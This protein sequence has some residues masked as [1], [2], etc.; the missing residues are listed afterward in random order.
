MKKIFLILL[1][2]YTSLSIA[3]SYEKHILQN[4]YDKSPNT[5]LFC[6]IWGFLKFYHP[7]VANG[8][9]NWELEF[10]NKIDSF[11]KIQEK[12]EIS[13]FLQN[14]IGKL[15]TFKSKLKKENARNKYFDKNFNLSW[16]SDTIY[17]EKNLIEKLDFIKNNRHQGNSYYVELGKN[18]NI[19]EKFKPQIDLQLYPTRNERL[20]CICQFWN[21]IEY[22]FPYKYLTD[23]NWDAVLNE[24]VTKS[25]NVRNELE[26]DLLMLELVNKTDDGH[27]IFKTNNTIKYFGSFFF[28]VEIKFI[29]EKAII[30]RLPND[31]LAKIDDLQI[32]DI[33]T[34]INNENISDIIEKKRKYLNGSNERAKLR[35]TYYFLA[36]GN[37]NSVKV[38]FN[39]NDS[40]FEKN[41]SRYYYD[42]IY[43]FKKNISKFKIL[44]NNIGLIDME[45]L[46]MKDVD[47]MMDSLK[48]TKGLI[49]DLRNYPKFIPYN[50]AKRFTKNETPCIDIIIPDLDFPGRFIFE[51]TITMKADKN[52]YDKPVIV[53][54]NENTQSRAEF[55]VMVFQSSPNVITLGSQ[56][57]GSNG[58]VSRIAISKTQSSLISG[59]GI[60]YP[61]DN[62][63]QRKG[64]KIDVEVNQ[65]IYGIK[66]NIDEQLFKAVEILNLN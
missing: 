53:I 16:I 43:K 39:R 40:I 22:F 19:I 23:Q 32:G 27:A 62:S 46:E 58:N 11:G 20:L 54:V 25:E 34:M 33:V 48:D 10:L 17:F 37:T 44:D 6:K 4:Q 21:T 57:A 51:K 56:T 52:Q 66:N 38:K 55:S 26:F 18:G 65:T 63:M 50:L 35:N 1:L 42:S 5:A 13:D 59:T 14:W 12:R 24:M 60:F 15:G 7:K 47:K 28:P 49:I 3:F 41:I 9:Y 29:E 64:V 30:S 36:N 31:S 45:N 8:N 2:L 61:N